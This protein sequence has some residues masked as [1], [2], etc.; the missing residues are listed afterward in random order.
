MK[1]VIT[2]VMCDMGGD[3]EGDRSARFVYDGREYSIDLCEEHDGEFVTDMDKWS[4]VATRVGRNAGSRVTPMVRSG[5]LDR[6]GQHR[7]A[8]QWAQENGIPVPSRG[9]VPTSV[10]EQYEQAVS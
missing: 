2:K 4:G 8:R 9:R 7:A 3:H 1:H 5:S 6:A 10:L